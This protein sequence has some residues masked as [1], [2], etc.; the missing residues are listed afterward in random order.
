VHRDGDAGRRYRFIGRFLELFEYN[1][2]A[3]ADA[4]VF[5]RMLDAMCYAGFSR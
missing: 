3:A 2:L 1:G 4:A 5:D